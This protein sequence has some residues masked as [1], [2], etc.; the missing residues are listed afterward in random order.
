MA[1]H[2]QDLHGLFRHL[3]IAPEQVAG[4]LVAHAL[5]QPPQERVALVQL[6]QRQRRHLHLNS[7]NLGFGV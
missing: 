4:V 3:S 2:L 6:A 1:A 7:S 5:S